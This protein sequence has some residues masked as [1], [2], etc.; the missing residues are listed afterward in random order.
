MNLDLSKFKKIG[1][2][3]THTI[4][5]HPDGHTIHISHEAIKPA[6]KKDLKGLPDKFADGG[7]VDGPAMGANAAIA[8]NEDLAGNNSTVPMS[9]DQISQMQLHNPVDPSQQPNTVPTQSPEGAYADVPGY[10]EAAK[11]IFQNQSA[12]SDLAQQNANI[13]KE[14]GNK[15]ASATQEFQKGMQEKMKTIQDVSK[16]IQDSKIDPHHYVENMSSRQ[17]IMTAIGFVLGG[18]GSGLAHQENMASKFF[19]DQINRDV[20][21]QKANIGNKHNL[22]SALERQYGDSMVAENMFKAIRANGVANQLQQAAASSGDLQAQA[23][24]NM[25]IGK[26]K[27]QYFPMVMRAQAMDSVNKGTAPSDPSQLVQWMVPK[28]RQKE[29]FDEIQSAQVARNSREKLLA[30]F[31]QAAKDNTVLKTGAGQLRTPPS[32]LALRVEAMPVLKDASGRVNE[33]EQHTLMNA[34]PKPGD[35]DSTIATK[36][37]AYEAL[38]D[39][40]MAGATA[41]GYGLDLG[42]F[43]S[44]SVPKEAQA[45]AEVKTMGGVQYQKVPGGWKRMQ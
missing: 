5:Q 34:E 3:K 22:L 41:K 16:D 23:R 20:E 33:M 44:T 40:K 26:L 24:A 31:D 4:M 21:A 37:K 42:K 1:S 11:G 12:Q 27:E 35:F 45:P 18:I 9:P 36:R 2:S 25:E 8:G 13:L 43:E 17:K 19:N 6:V 10:K 39:K 7:E 29:V 38:L 32:V 28:E 30:M 14:A 15:E